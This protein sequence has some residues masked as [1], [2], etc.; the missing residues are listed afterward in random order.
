[1]FAPWPQA[2]EELGH[3]RGMPGLVSG[4]RWFWALG[5]SGSDVWSLAFAPHRPRDEGAVGIFFASVRSEAAPHPPVTSWLFE[6]SAAFEL[7]KAP[8]SV[9][10]QVTAL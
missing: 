6:T 8:R 1:M 7:G 3:L 4:T 9:E 5:I 2:E 10:E